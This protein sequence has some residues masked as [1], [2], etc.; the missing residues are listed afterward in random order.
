MSWLV[1]LKIELLDYEKKKKGKLV[2]IFLPT[3]FDYN[4]TKKIISGLTHYFLIEKKASFFF[5]L[6]ISLS[7]FVI[8]LF[9]SQES[10]CLIAR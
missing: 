10:V 8:D 3:C 6:K 1:F 4:C 5:F 9:E 2:T 7:F